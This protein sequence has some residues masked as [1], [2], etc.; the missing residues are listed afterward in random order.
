[1][2]GISIGILLLMSL[3]L[4]NSCEN[5]NTIKTANAVKLELVNAEKNLQKNP[6][7]ALAIVNKALLFS[8]KNIVQDEKKLALLQLKQRAFLKLQKMDSVCVTGQ[9]IR[10]V[11][12]RI[13]DSLAI[14]ETL[15]KLYVDIDYK[16]LKEAKPYILGGIKTFENE[17]KEYEKGILIELYGRIM[18]EEGNFKNSQNYLLKAAEIFESKGNSKDM[19]I[20]YKEL[21]INFSCLGIIDKSNYYYRKALKN[22]EIRKDSIQQASVLLNY[23]I[24]FKTRNSN[25]AIKMYYRALNL[26]P[27]NKGAKLRMKLEFNLANLYLNQKD[28]DKATVVF[29]R[30]LEEAT[31]ANYQEGKIMATAALGNV[32]GIKKEYA[33]SI[34]YYK[35][36]LK[37]LVANDQNEIILMLLPEL[38]SVSE[39]SGD[40]KMAYHYSNQLN[41][42]KDSLLTIEKTK[43]VLELE[44]KYQVEKKDLEIG[45][46]KSLSNSRLMLLYGLC[47]FVL[48]LFFV[49]R[50]QLKLYK[51][52]QYSYNLL[53]QQYK[54]ERLKKF[55]NKTIKIQNPSNV[56]DDSTQSNLDLFVKLEAYYESEKPYLNSKLK[57]SDVAKALLV[58]QR[59]I[60]ATIKANGFSSFNNFNNK[61]RIE[62]VKKQ[63]EDPTYKKFKMEVIAQQAGF[64]NKQSFYLAF[65]E[66][67]GLHPG[68]YRAE[69]LKQ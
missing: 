35:K 46:L 53:I 52:K 10:E 54:T 67:T 63:F 39:N 2:K 38:I 41:K 65:E 62:D 27:V 1:M 42:L 18:N 66:Y 59:I 3:G 29:N 6:D 64:G 12:S 49:L 21:G 4:L 31:K 68:F 28:F 40:F 34:G 8:S 5:K 19:G 26:L 37:T 30:I 9:K 56:L 43:T 11:A 23:G 45:Y 17:N 48:I 57:A 24:N 50:K 55:E 44:K 51:E 60:S 16:Y 33:R 58:P 20:V 14:A 32:Y 7:S 36:A 15:L 47:F 22:A 13:P 61:Y 69:I 25:V